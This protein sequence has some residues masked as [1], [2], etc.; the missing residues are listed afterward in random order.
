MQK[1]RAHT[2]DEYLIPI[3]IWEIIIGIGCIILL[4]VFIKYLLENQD[5]EE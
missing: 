4:Y 1:K 3:L 5:K 2:L